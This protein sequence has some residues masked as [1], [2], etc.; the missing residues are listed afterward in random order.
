MTSGEDFQKALDNLRDAYDRIARQA[1]EL[2]YEIVHA[3][4]YESQYVQ[5]CARSTCG[6]K[7]LKGHPIK[8][9]QTILGG[10]EWV[11]E[12]CPR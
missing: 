6:N 11:H 4:K 8:L 1:A 10:R 5:D 3:R 9:I 7:P 2:G 12:V